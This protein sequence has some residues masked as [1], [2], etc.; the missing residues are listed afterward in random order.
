MVRPSKPGGHKVFLTV[1]AI[2]GVCPERDIGIAC[3]KDQENGKIKREMFT[4]DKRT[5][6]QG[7]VAEGRLRAGPPGTAPSAPSCHGFQS[8]PPPVFV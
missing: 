7:A 2:P 5:D 8:L 6:C 4:S 3:R 1:S